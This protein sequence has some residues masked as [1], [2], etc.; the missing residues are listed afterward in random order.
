M[1]FEADTTIHGVAQQCDSGNIT[2]SSHQLWMRMS[3]NCVM[4]PSKP[5][6]SD[7][8]ERDWFYFISQPIH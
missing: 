6:W 5:H 7:E 1:V 4:H 2:G 3:W 8:G